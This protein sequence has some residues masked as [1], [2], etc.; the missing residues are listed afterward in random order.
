MDNFAVNKYLVKYIVSQQINDLVTIVS[1]FSSNIRDL[2]DNIY[3]RQ[4]D[5]LVK[6]LANIENSR[7]NEIYLDSIYKN[8]SDEELEII[9]SLELDEK[10]VHN[11]EHSEM[12]GITYY[13]ESTFMAVLEDE[14]KKIKESYNL[15]ANDDYNKL[16]DFF[17]SIK[18]AIKASEDS[19]VSLANQYAFL[20]GHNRDSLSPEYISI[21]GNKKYKDE[22]L[23]GLLEKYNDRIKE[24]N[25]PKSNTKKRC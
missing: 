1:M 14:I 15:R 7:K 5:I 8:V 2:E 17:I 24:I 13:D 21:H 18:T 20:L 16:L 11:L 10:V 12:L 6:I 4:N 23:A 19:L 22:L 3:V 25:K 9:E